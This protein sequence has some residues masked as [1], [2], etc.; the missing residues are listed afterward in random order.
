MLFRSIWSNSG[1]LSYDVQETRAELIET[2]ASMPDFM[3]DVYKR[4]PWRV[5]REIFQLF[6]AQTVNLAGVSIAC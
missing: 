3:G 2:N 5:I 6:L 1:G 4:Q